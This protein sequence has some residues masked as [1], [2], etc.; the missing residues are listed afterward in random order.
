V[1]QPKQDTTNRKWCAGLS[2]HIP[3]PGTTLRKGAGSSL[4]FVRYFYNFRLLEV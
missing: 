4:F 1:D 3:C 2:K